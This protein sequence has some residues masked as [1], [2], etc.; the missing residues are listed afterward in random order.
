MICRGFAELTPAIFR[1]LYLAMV[2]PQLDYAGS[3]A[4]S[5][6]RSEARG[7]DA[8][9]CD[10]MREGPTWIA[11]YYASARP[12]ASAHAEPHSSVN[13][14]QGLQFILRQPEP[15]SGIV[16]RCASCKSPL[17]A[18]I[19]D[20]AATI[21][22]R[23][24]ESSIRSSNGRAVEQTTIPC[25]ESDIAKCVQGAAQQLLGDYFP[26]SCLIPCKYIE[27]YIILARE[28]YFL[29]Q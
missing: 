10:A 25:R 12:T 19:Q 22:T 16:F 14:N 2:R 15:A 26:R 23:P 6:K 9:A 1:P 20:P 17:W 18:S 28:C 8:K 7:E 5:P 13:V 21:P 29:D 3:G 24:M 4:V 11:L 27:N